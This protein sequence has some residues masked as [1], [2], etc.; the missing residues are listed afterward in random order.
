M[1]RLV[2]VLVV[3]VV[4]IVSIP[5]ILL[6]ISDHSQAQFD[7]QPKVIGASTPVK[8]KVTN[9]HGIRDVKIY[10]DQNGTQT[11][12][13]DTKQPATRWTFWRKHETP[14]EYKFTVTGKKDGKARLVAEVTSND[15]RGSHDTVAA[16]V[17]VITRPPTVVADGLEHII[18][19]GG[20]ELVLFTPSGYWTE[21]GAKEANLLF[22]S[23]PKPGS[24]TER[25]A[26]FAFPWNMPVDTQVFAYATNPTGAMATS[27][28]RQIVKPRKFRRRDFELSDAFM[29]KVVNELDPGGS[30]DLVTRFVKINHDMRIANNKTLADLRDKTEQRYLWSGPFVHNAAVESYF[31]D[32]RTYL[33]KGKKVDEEVHLGFDLAGTQHMP[34]TAANSGKVVYA[35]RLGIYGNCVVLDHGYGLQS[36]YGHMSQITVKVGDMIQKGQEMGRSGSTGMAGGDHV[37]FSLQV[38]GVQVNPVDWWDPHWIHDRVLSKVPAQ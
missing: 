12:L 34:V 7:P 13:V 19:Q 31:A 37:H 36:I 17:D 2:I 30:G 32:V 15:L 21:S 26:L 8:L 22:R 4:I 23:F 6:S 14:A 16:D 35:N 33:Y 10:L 1:S 24:T 3:L 11:T 27:P 38:D 28:I 5:V 20:T 29:E 25:F 9:P 18:Y